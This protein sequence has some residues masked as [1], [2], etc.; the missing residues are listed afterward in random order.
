M[1]T[2]VVSKEEFKN[3]RPGSFYFS[4]KAEKSLFNFFFESNSFI[5]YVQTAV[6]ESALRPQSNHL[7]Y[8]I[9]G[10]M[11]IN[12]SLLYFLDSSYTEA[13][14]FPACWQ[15]SICSQTGLN[16]FTAVEAFGFFATYLSVH[17]AGNNSSSIQQYKTR[18][19]CL[20]QLFEAK[21]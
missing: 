20:L 16:R 19:T 17:V 9:E 21:P 14:H 4:R 11:L 3:F 12:Y 18:Q 1:C 2:I 10:A 13:E 6:T 5:Y 8:G 15:Y 7:K